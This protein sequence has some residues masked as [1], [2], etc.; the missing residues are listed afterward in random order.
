DHYATLSVPPHATPAQIKSQFYTLSKLHHPD[1]NPGN[2]SSAS[3]F[4]AISEAYHVLSSPAARAK[5]DAQFTR[6]VHHRHTHPT[7]SHSS[8]AAGP[9]GSR[10]ASGLSRRRT[11]FKGPPPSFYRSG[12]YG[13]HS[14][15]RTEHQTKAESAGSGSTGGMGF[16]QEVPGPEPFIPHW[17]RA[18]HFRTH[19]SIR[20]W[21]ETRAERGRMSGLDEE[22]VGGSMIV[23]FFLVTG[24][25]ALVIAVP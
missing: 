22:R 19:E 9:A 6:P 20:K 10:P 11:Q 4:V 1:R 7:G 24:V 17:D 3:K 12:G 13:A 21:R 25:V 15:K 14:A 5:Y 16:G 2:P 18:G 8:H 23:N